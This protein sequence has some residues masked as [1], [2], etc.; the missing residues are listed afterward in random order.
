MHYSAE[1]IPVVR[2][3]WLTTRVNSQ[4]FSPHGIG[5]GLQVL[6]DS[7][8]SFSQRTQ[9]VLLQAHTQ[10]SAPLHQ[11]LK[12][13]SATQSESR[14]LLVFLLHCNS[15]PPSLYLVSGGQCFLFPPSPPSSTGLQYL[16]VL[17]QHLGQLRGSSQLQRLRALC[18]C[19]VCVWCVCVLCACVL[20]G[21]VCVVVCKC[22]VSVGVC[23]WCVCVRKRNAPT[24]TDRSVHMCM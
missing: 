22:V 19:G 11:C 20:C 14:A 24:D 8:L 3:T 18:V 16:N 1:S 6:A 17:S 7:S 15:W 12:K 2:H 23:M 21:G 9:S 5:P 13:D 4:R 10:H